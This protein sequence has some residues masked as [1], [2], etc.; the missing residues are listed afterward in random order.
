MTRYLSY[1]F[2]VL[3]LFVTGCA[4]RWVVVKQA[5]PNPLA[6]QK[7]NVEKPS[8]EGLMVGGKP[9]AEWQ[10]SKEDKDKGDWKAD[11]EGFA[12]EFTNAYMAS[13]GPVLAGEGGFGVKTWVVWYEP[14][15][16]AFAAARPTEVR[17]KVQIVDPKGA[18]VDEITV[19]SVVQSTMTTPSSGQRLRRAG[20]DLGEV[21]AKYVKTRVVGE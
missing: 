14:G 6:G 4:P 21:V 8:Y 19:N 3:A 2:L 12:E 20:T 15:F 17:I 13:K 5:S 16:Y 7:I 11:K 1:A 18:V 9:E 10:G